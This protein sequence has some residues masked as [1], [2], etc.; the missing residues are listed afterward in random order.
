MAKH[1]PWILGLTGGIGSGKSTASAYLA[2]QGIVVVDADKVARQ[3]VEPNSVGLNAIVAR[4]GATILNTDG[5]LE[6][7]KLRDIIFNDEHEKAWLNALLHPLIRQS[8]LAQ[9]AQATGPYVILE[10]PLLF[11]NNLTQYCNRTLLIDIPESVQ[12]T[13][14]CSR[15][16]TTPEQARAIIQSQL[17]RTEKITQTDDMICNIG[18]KAD[19]NAK[20]SHYHNCYLR[21]AKLHSG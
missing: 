8:M 18:T 13:R 5:S 9:L 16:K 20:L 15:D 21:L 12:I 4:H 17:S 1:T 11:E 6:R 3:V 2:K 19:L 7:A 14:T 10:A